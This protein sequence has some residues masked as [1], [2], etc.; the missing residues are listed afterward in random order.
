MRVR[1][2]KPVTRRTDAVVR[3]GGE[4]GSLLCG[5]KFLPISSGRNR[6][7][8]GEI[9]RNWEKMIEIDLAFWL[10]RRKREK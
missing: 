6:E 10:G 2:V 9:G 7:E 1:S 5:M 4:M 8:Y 3:R